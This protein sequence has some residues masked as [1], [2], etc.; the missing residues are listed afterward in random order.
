MVVDTV[1]FERQAQAQ[2]MLA[3]AMASTKGSQP[4]EEV[5]TAGSVRNAANN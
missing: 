1:K 4:K 5:E 2:A 3:R